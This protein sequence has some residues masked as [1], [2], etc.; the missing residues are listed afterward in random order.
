[1][2]SNNNSSLV[3]QLGKKT[4][5]QLNNIC[6]VQK[7]NIQALGVSMLKHANSVTETRALEFISQLVIHCWHL[8]MNYL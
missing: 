7:S 6:I 1:M 4:N 3:W 5:K 2:D 8:E